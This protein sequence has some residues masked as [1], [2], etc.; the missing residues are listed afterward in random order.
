MSRILVSLGWLSADFAL[1]RFVMKQVPYL[2][3]LL[4]AATSPAQ[5]QK[6]EP[7]VPA[8][9]LIPRLEECPAS[10]RD[11]VTKLVQ[12]Q[13]ISEIKRIEETGRIIYVFETGREDGGKDA[14]VNYHFS[15]EG[16]LL[17]T[18]EDMEFKKAPE[19]VQ[20]ALLKLAGS[21]AVVDDVERVTEGRAVSYKAELESNGGPDRKVRMSPEGAV[22][23]LTA[24]EDD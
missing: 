4:L 21:G 15:N 9:R 2:L 24:E 7:K 20:Q 10:V 13:A 19:A 18:E 23:E 11:A 14:E 22:L 6:A 17:K 5:G 16:K 1:Q 8:V 3:S 12:P